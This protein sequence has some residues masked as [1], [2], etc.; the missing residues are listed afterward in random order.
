MSSDNEN[1]EVVKARRRLLKLAVYVPPAVIGTLALN[2]V[3]CQVA[4]CMPANC[5]PAICMP[6]DN[7]MPSA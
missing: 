3:A 6:A 7:C 2:T 5:M 4:S 1:S